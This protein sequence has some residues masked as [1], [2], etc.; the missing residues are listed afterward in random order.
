M[1]YIP[2]EHRQFLDA[3]IDKLVLSVMVRRVVAKKGFAGFVNYAVTRLLLKLLGVTDM[4]PVPAEGTHTY[5]A[6]NEMIGALECC[7]LELYRRLAAPYEDAKIEQNGE[8]VVPVEEPEPPPT[9]ERLA[10][11][12]KVGGRLWDAFEPPQQEFPVPGCH[13]TSCTETRS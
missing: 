10:L 11:I 5:A 2:K 6:I 1:P 9:P 13:C 7:K 12:A 8:V 4:G 3:W